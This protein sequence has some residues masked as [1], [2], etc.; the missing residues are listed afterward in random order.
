MWKQHS[1][2]V[3]RKFDQCVLKLLEVSEIF[4]LYPNVQLFYFSQC[5]DIS[6]IGEFSK[7]ANHISTDSDP[8]R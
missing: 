7:L 8:D 4:G 3:T 1:E 6:A 2:L 5:N